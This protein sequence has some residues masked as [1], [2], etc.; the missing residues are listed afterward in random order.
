MLH[1][2][3]SARMT[4][5]R[6]HLGEMIL[7]RVVS[8]G[9]DVPVFEERQL[10]VVM[11]VQGALLT[12]MGE[13]TFKIPARHMLIASRGHRMTRVLKPADG[14]FKALVLMIDQ[15]RI[16][17]EATKFGSTRGP[18]AI[19]GDFCVVA[20]GRRTVQSRHLFEISRI[21]EEDLEVDAGRTGG[22][23]CS[24]SAWETVLTDKL[25]DLLAAIELAPSIPDIGPVVAVRHVR[26][27]VDYMR[28]H[29]PHITSMAEVAAVCGVSVRTLESAFRSVMDGS[30][31]EYLTRIRLDAARELLLHDSGVRGTADA[32]YAC[33]FGHAGRFAS[34]YRARF[35]E[36]PSVTLG[37]RLNSPRISRNG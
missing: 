30:P 14:N 22:S 23:S 1:D 15:S 19:G 5:D 9:H 3:R 11:P 17:C 18:H 34:L 16:S 33:G 10:T 6:A 7:G 21:L 29:F 32:A 13:R 31:K 8:T 4:V 36:T 28:A 26:T 37:R 2:D 24:V 25:L 35:D 20:D 12:E 27:A